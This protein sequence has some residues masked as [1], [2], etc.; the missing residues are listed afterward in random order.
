MTDTIT[1]MELV[2]ADLL[3]PS[4]LMEGDLINID[5][6]IVEVIS[7]VDDA[8]GDNYIITHRNEYGEE[9]EYYCTY[10]EMFKLYVFIDLDEQSWASTQDFSNRC[11]KCPF[12]VD[13][14]HF[15]DLTL[16]RF[17]GMIKL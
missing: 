8:T 12:Y 6:D 1:R 5:M 15:Q 14:T 4:Q 7:I 13:Y 2:Y 17:F 16:F 10:E 11:P 9:Y 3:T